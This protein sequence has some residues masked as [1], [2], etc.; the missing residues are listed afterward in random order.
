MPHT[1][2]T[3]KDIARAMGVSATTVHRALHGK[4]GVGEETCVEIR[5]TAAQMGYRTNYM[6]SALKRREVRLGIVLP[7]PTLDNRYYYL[8]LW[9]G[10]QRF[11]SEVTEFAVR[12]LEFPYPLGPGSNGV[13]LKEVYEQH[14][15]TLDGLLTIAVDHSQSSYFLEKL[16]AKGVPITLVGANLYPDIRLCCVKAYDELAGSLAAELLCAFYPGE[17]TGKIIVTGNPVGSFSM[18]D[19][20]YNVT[21]FTQY[22]A[23]RAPNVTL[24][25]A[26]SADAD[27][28]GRQV[29]ALLSQHPDVYAIYASSA[30]H[31]VQM[32]RVLET[33]G[34]A[35]KVKL[36]GN[37][38]FTESVE[39]LALGTLTA[40]IDKKIAEQSYQAA[41]VL[42]NYVIKGSYP[43]SST[44]QV[45]PAVIL[46]G[47]ATSSARGQKNAVHG[48]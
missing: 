25:T 28:A 39:L 17:L 6:A 19:Q 12:L 40:V 24:L 3:L 44:I 31:T 27:S 8:S 20:Y 5:R 29:Q 35:G 36:V 14:A 21:G 48:K 43:A 26:Y 30:R 1:H 10:A 11:F 32:G 47:N 16:A 45:E 42:F 15:D 41:Q 13:A 46:A 38:R 22:L 34:L 4:A 33:F 9:Q 2:P 7:E 18:V 23:R 37:D